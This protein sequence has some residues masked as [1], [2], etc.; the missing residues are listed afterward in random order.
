M[1]ARKRLSPMRASEFRSDTRRRLR[2]LEHEQEVERQR[3]VRLFEHL[4]TLQHM[5]NKFWLS[6]N[7]RFGPIDEQHRANDE[8]GRPAWAKEEYA[9]QPMTGGGAK[10]G[11]S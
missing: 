5:V 3:V 11:R 10:G 6:I 8:P 9:E 1:A 4:D 2:I 7:K